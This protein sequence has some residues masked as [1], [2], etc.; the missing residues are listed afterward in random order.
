[1]V[2]KFECTVVIKFSLK[3]I[4]SVNKK[5]QAELLKPKLTNLDSRQL[6]TT[7]VPTN[8]YIMNIVTKIL[9]LTYLREHSFLHSHRHIILRVLINR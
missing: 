7:Q 5:T 4:V 6:N 9:D 2:R 1:M 8:T 3:N